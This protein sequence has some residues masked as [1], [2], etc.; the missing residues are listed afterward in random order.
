MS[1]V[2]FV[3]LSTPAHACPTRALVEQVQLEVG[4]R[5]DE[6]I[7]LGKKSREASGADYV[8][9]NTLEMVEGAQAGAFLIG[10]DGHE[11]VE[12]EKLPGRMVELVKQRYAGRSG[13]S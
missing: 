2:S 7:A 13:R 5:K 11:W 1:F 12:R 3:F 8:V 9:A 6:L 4:L 10:K